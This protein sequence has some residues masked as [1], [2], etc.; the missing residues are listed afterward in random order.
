MGKPIKDMFLEI[1]EAWE[2]EWKDQVGLYNFLDE[3]VEINDEHRTY[4]I[5]KRKKRPEFD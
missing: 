1:A 5:R 4:V 2:D 3:Y